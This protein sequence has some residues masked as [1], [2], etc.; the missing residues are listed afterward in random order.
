[1][2]QNCRL[3]L[4]LVVLGLALPGC[5]FSRRAADA[6]RTPTV[7]TGMGAAVIL[8]GETLPSLPGGNAAPGHSRTTRSATEGS[9]EASIGSAQPS[10]GNL[11]QIGGSGI[12]QNRHESGKE[13]PLIFKW[14]TAPLGLL[15]A[16]FAWAAEAARGEPEPG[17]PVPRAQAPRAKAQPAPQD[18][19]TQNIQRMEEE[20]A[21]RGPPRRPSAKP[22]HRPSA[23]PAH[24]PS[25]K[26][27]HRPSAKPAHRPSAKPAHLSI[28]DELAALQR[29]PGPPQAPAPAVEEAPV[30]RHIDPRVS[31]ALRVQNTAPQQ[32]PATSPPQDPDLA[33]DGIVDR[34]DDGRIDQWI[35]RHDGQIV[36]KLLD[37]DFDGRPDT[38]LHYDPL[39]H[40]IARVEED[41]N[42]DGDV[43]TWT[44]YREGQ[45]QRRRVD[46]NGDA[47]VDT[48][49]YYEDGEITRHEQDSTSDGFRDRI[50]HYVNGR[51]IRD[52]H[53]T[54]GDGR[55]D[56]TT[57]YDAQERVVRREEDSD[58]DGDIDVIVHYEDGRLARKELLGVPTTAT[59]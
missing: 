53:D 55:P 29:S 59:P 9:D 32:A 10:T 44:S 22:A 20:L 6:D 35:Y 24:R 1:M 30:E 39:S 46:G 40:R 13:D 4:V 26:P 8:P 51:L 17:P 11:T 33:A 25:A 41:S 3:V 19:D 31:A 56:I 45:I 12:D 38:T 7:D 42:R 14:L 52:Q 37:Q 34:D 27:A 21:Q 16:P 49:T 57:H 54:N 48:W 18:Y 58:G 23:K 47:E 15:A 43:D 5:Y 50:G 28:A 2:P 36:R